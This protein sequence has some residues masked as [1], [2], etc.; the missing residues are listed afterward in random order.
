MTR[1]RRAASGRSALC[2]AAALLAVCPARADGPPAWAVHAPNDWLVVVEA[3]DA[4]SLSDRCQRLAE[5]WG[6]DLPDVLALAAKSFG[7]EAIGDEAWVFALVEGDDGRVSPL[8]LAPIEDFD[9]LCE[10]LDADRAGDIAIA[11]FAN[12]E[13]A[14]AD[15]ERWARVTLVDDVD[16]IAIGNARFAAAPDG[17][18]V[19]RTSQR[20]RRWLTEQLAER[21]QRNPRARN[22]EAWQWRDGLRV[23][24]ARLAQWRPVS[25]TLAGLPGEVAVSLGYHT[26]DHSGDDEL[27]ATVRLPVGSSPAE[28][29]KIEP[30]AIPAGDAIVSARAS[31]PIPGEL[32]DL[33]L[34]VM[35]SQPS[36][37][38]AAEYPQPQWD[39]FA[40]AYRQLLVGYR[41]FHGVLATPRKGGPVAA[42]QSI[43][44]RWAGDDES[45]ENLLHLLVVR[46]NLLNVTANARTPHRVAIEP[47]EAG[48]WRLLIDLVEAFGLRR[49]PEIEALLNRYY[50]AGGELPLVVTPIGESTYLITMGEPPANDDR[51]TENATTANNEL[52][53]IE[54]AFWLNRWLAWSRQVA[55][56]DADSAGPEREPMLES[57]PARVTVRYTESGQL[58]AEFRLPVMTYKAGVAWRRS[59]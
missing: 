32:I 37:I 56:I 58:D 35:Q 2:L 45:F 1:H 26:S 38:G 21:R 42:N 54:G 55:L 22:R 9:A 47:R 10:R 11:R 27:V 24:L 14:I 46:W 51:A 31:G 44:F 6:R 30:P 50:G 15:G 7:P 3:R 20:G 33:A 16:R 34:A 29:E 43:A 52:P 57:P 8:L 12:Y 40:D 53:L 59:E 19:L 18:V 49:T 39:D 48:G 23:A 41:S 36:T 13:L 17:D 5:P 25:R 28:K 4:A